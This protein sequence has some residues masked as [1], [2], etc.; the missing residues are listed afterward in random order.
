MGLDF[1]IAN[2]VGILADGVL[3]KGFNALDGQD[4][5]EWLAKHGANPLTLRSVLPRV[6]YDAAMS[7]VDGD[8]DRQSIAAGSA[9]RALHA[10]WPHV[11]GTRGLRV[12]R[13]HG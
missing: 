6:I 13:L 2:L 4:Y 1:L 12:H 3:T 7:M 5:R 11:P 10:Y 8:P 9:L